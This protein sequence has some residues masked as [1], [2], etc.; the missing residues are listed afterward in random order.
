MRII[1]GGWKIVSPPLDWQILTT[2]ILVYIQV[3]D[4]YI[5]LRGCQR[6]VFF[7]THA[8]YRQNPFTENQFFLFWVI[9]ERSLI[10]KMI[11]N[12]IFEGMT[13]ILNVHF[14]FFFFESN[15]KPNNNKI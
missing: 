15:T 13:S 2:E 12:N 1:C 11:K 9:L 5:H 4:F 10:T 3:L 8:K 14:F 6:I 7:L